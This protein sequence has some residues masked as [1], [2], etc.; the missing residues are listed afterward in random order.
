MKI[1]LFVTTLAV[2]AVLAGGAAMADRAEDAVKARRGYFQMLSFNLG[3]LAAM[4]KGEVDY[5]AV[6]AAKFT[7]NLDALSDVDLGP[8]F[9]PGTD[10]Q[11][12][13]GKT[14]SLPAIWSN[15]TG[16]VGRSE[17]FNEA[18][19][20]LSIAA[21]QGLNPL[22]SEIGKV[23]GACKACHDDFRAKDF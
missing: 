1:K 20:L 22:R 15:P 11:A 19:D 13:A 18:I 12:M 6:A 7:A 14:R 21:A 3:G 17:D 8:L 5:N 2:A 4:A 9:L 23:G 16:L 10:N